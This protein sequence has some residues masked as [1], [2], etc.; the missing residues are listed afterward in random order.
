MVGQDPRSTVADVEK[1]MAAAASADLAS[2]WMSQV[3]AFDALTVIAAAGSRVPRIELGTAVVPT[4]PRHPQVLAQQA[5]TVQA[6]TGGRLALG[7]GLSHQIVIE[8]MYGYS[9]ERPLRHMKEYLS[10]LYPLT[11][12]ETTDFIGETMRWSGPLSVVGASP[13]PV[14]VAALG[15]AM[16]RLAGQMADGTVT[17]MAGPRTVET[18][19]A[20][21]I[22]T[23]AEEAGRPRPRV[24]VALPVCVTGDTQKARERAASVFSVYGQLPSYRA[25][26]DREGADGPADVA[27]VGDEPNVVRAV[28]GLSDVGVDDLIAVN[29]GSRDERAA[30]LSTLS[31]ISASV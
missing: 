5:L 24:A 13:P 28:T 10:I 8:N 17:W 15:P 20:P 23:A 29:F 11:R 9:F 27:I 19:I 30:T 22:R 7:I 18:H 1:E 14:L 21:S 4:Y 6:A 31:S 26:L 2:A 12:G 25:M 3:F 16:L